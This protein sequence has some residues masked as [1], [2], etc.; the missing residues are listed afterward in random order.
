MPR[1]QSNN[2]RPMT[3]SYVA[4]HKLNATTTYELNRSRSKSFTR[5]LSAP[6]IL[7]L[8]S[9]SKELITDPN[10]VGVEHSRPNMLCPCCYRSI[11]PRTA[12]KS[13]TSRF[14]C[15]EFCA[16]SEI[17]APVEQCIQMEV[18]NRQYVERL[19]RLLPFFRDL[20]SNRVS[21]LSVSA[22]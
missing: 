18:L 13:S 11:D 4:S 7:A 12:W 21:P 8:T 15:G 1:S 6:L 10:V 3:C 19:R 20:K 5:S 16:D 14:Y 17:S 22:L 9:E 2:P